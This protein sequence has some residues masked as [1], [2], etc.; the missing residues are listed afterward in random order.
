MK[1]RPGGKGPFSSQH[2]VEDTVGQPQSYPLEK[3][4][5]HIPAQ[6]LGSCQGSGPGGG[7][8]GPAPAGLATTLA[9]LSEGWR[10]HE[11]GVIGSTSCPAPPPEPGQG[12]S[13]LPELPGPGRP[14]PR[15]LPPTPPP[16]QVTPPSPLCQSFLP[17]PGRDRA[18]SLAKLFFLSLWQPVPW[19]SE[20]EGQG[21]G[22]GGSPTSL[23]DSHRLEHLQLI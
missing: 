14:T 17:T 5:F 8:R 23:S 10:L 15:C 4:L 2:H 12:H 22:W 13:H 11:A 6:E 7:G 3:A 1:R 18:H 19:L 20:P 21:W 16:P 9:G